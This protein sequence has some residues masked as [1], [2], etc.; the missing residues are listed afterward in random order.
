M[1]AVNVHMALADRVLTAWRDGVA[2]PVFD[3]D[4][5]VLRNAFYNGA[6]G[7]DLGYFPGGERVLSELSHGVAPATLLRNLVAGVTTEAERAFAF[8]WATHVLGDQLIHPLIGFGV[9]EALTGRRDLFVS[10]KADQ[11]THIRVEIGLDSFFALRNPRFRE[12]RLRPVFDSATI[13]YLDHAYERTYGIRVGRS[14]LLRCHA[15]VSDAARIALPV[16]A[17]V[18]TGV[19]HR[20]VRRKARRVMH[21]AS[22]LVRGRWGREALS[23]AALTPVRPRAW[24]MRSVR[25]IEAG[26]GDRFLALAEGG[27]AALRDL[28]MESGREA[29]SAPPPDLLEGLASGQRPSQ[30]PSF[31][32]AHA[33][34]GAPRPAPGHSFGVGRGGVR[35]DQRSRSESD[36]SLSRQPPPRARRF[37]LPFRRVVLPAGRDPT[38]G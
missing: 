30:A 26:F 6:F 25:A 2:P 32:F 10:G 36:E 29:W 8:G 12:R 11:V 28:D 3:V 5:P 35:P 34:D 37:G 31:T 18:G 9:G 17:A 19:F 23:V 21:R 15:G 20:S 4:D 24:L 1:P 13:R 22:D 7:P 33:S 16:I 14:T 27:F 38:G